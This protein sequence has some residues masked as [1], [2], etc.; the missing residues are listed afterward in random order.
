MVDKLQDFI[1][2]NIVWIFTLA[3]TVLGSYYQIHENAT[4]IDIG[5]QRNNKRYNRGLELYEEVKTDNEKLE[6]ELEDFKVDQSYT[7][8]YN[9][10][11][12]E[13]LEKQLK[14]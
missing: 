1:G 6:Q 9:K 14:K 4:H 7:N 2:K 5:E 3:A 13:M 12:I 11:M 8:G 10:A